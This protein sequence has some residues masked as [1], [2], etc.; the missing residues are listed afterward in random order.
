MD[1]EWEVR[2]DLK[3]SELWDY[4]AGYN[5]KKENRHAQIRFWANV[6]AG[7]E[8]QE[9]IGETGRVGYIMPSF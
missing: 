7:G 1:G 5:S 2:I 6:Q 4:L 3:T 8:G 9:E